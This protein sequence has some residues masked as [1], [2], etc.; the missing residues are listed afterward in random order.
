MR[1]TCS[2]MKT[3]LLFA[4][5]GIAAAGANP[6]PYKGPAGPPLVDTAPGFFRV[7]EADGRWWLIDPVGRAFYAVGTDHIL[8][9]GHGC[10]RLGYAP[11][12]RAATA[13]YGSQE[14]WTIATMQRL[15]D[16]GFNTLAASH[17]P[18]LRH[19]DL[20]HIEFLGLGMDFAKRDALCPQ[21]TW[22]GFPNVF[23]P[24]WPTHCDEFARRR[25][26][27]HRD[28]PWL[29]GYFLDNEL[30]WYGKAWMPY[31]LFQEAW[32]LP[33]DHTGKQA[34]ITFLKR[35][36][37]DPAAFQTHWGVRIEDFAALGDHVTPGPPLSDRAREMALRWVTEVGELYFKHA[38][39]AIRKHDPNHLILGCRFAG[40]SPGAWGPAGRYCEVVSFNYY[41]NI[42]LRRGVPDWFLQK[43]TEFHREA[44]RPLMITEWS[45]PALD[46]ELP[47]THGA[48]MRVDNQTQRTQ[49]FEHFQTAM[50][51]LPFMVGSNFFMYLDEPELGISASFPENSNYGLVNNA[52]EPYTLLTAAAARLNPKVYEIH[53]HSRPH[54]PVRDR[55]LVPWLKE[56]PETSHATPIESITANCGDLKLTAPAGSSAWQLASGRIP[57]GRF[58]PL[59]HQITP[60]DCWERPQQA[61]IV[62]LRSSALVTVVDMEFTRP[63]EPARGDAQASTASSCRPRGYRTRWRFWMPQFPEPGVRIAGQKD[64]EETGW[65]ATQCLWVENTDT[66]PWTLGRIFHYLTPAIGGSDEG[67]EPLEMHVQRYHRLGAGWAD[68]A[69]GLGVGCW[70][71]PDMEFYYNYWKDEHGGF[72]ADLHE[73]PFVTL[74]PGQRYESAE[75]RRAFFLAIPGTTRE[76]F[77]QATCRVE[78]LAYEKP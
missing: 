70:L 71:P 31:G 55:W 48:G 68:K 74:Q 58:T 62:A 72:H 60:G 14:P 19:R 18:S 35:E 7:H 76:A 29:I 30:E 36:L 37:Q 11:Y 4:A 50:F 2:I 34:W 64:D 1:V 10:E 21:T 57:L 8:Y 44:G 66:E 43:V 9:Q 39:E 23:S 16:W 3:I 46:T 78:A 22:T 6:P 65:L 38:A 45:F 25:C 27:P 52:D 42:D 15:V 24:D 77:A 40:P 13:K 63:A 75:G 61:T 54:V 56:L 41:P 20:P 12:G 51:R 73:D 69:A 5:I 49:A 67:D 32:K 28:D 59:L 17:T 53:G 26:A 47:S 33:A